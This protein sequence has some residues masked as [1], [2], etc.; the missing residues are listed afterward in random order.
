MGKKRSWTDTMLAAAVAKNRSFWAVIL[1][2]GLV[3]AGGNYAQVL[4]RCQVL[5]LDTTHFTGKGWNAGDRWRHATTPRPLVTIL[6]ANSRYLS[7]GL[8]KRLFAAGYKTP[9]CELCGWAQESKDGRI[10]VELD[11]INGDHYDNQLENLRI[12]CPNCHGL[13]PTHQGKN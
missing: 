5:E 8:K 3:P 10:P 11:H 6:T 4:A 9:K 2:L 1:E 12:L 13:Q 7:F